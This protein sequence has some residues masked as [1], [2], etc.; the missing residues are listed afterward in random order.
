MKSVY[1]ALMLFSL[2]AFASPPLGVFHLRA[3]SGVAGWDALEYCGISE[4]G[5]DDQGSRA[6][7]D[8][9]ATYYLQKAADARC[10]GAEGSAKLIAKTLEIRGICSES[11]NIGPTIYSMLAVGRFKCQ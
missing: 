8:S 2:P 11:G 9:V 6:R 5:P 3:D 10:E 7:R 1:L 4:E